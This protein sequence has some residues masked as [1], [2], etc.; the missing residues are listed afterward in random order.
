MTNKLITPQ[1]LYKRLNDGKEIIGIHK[2]R[3]LVK[4]KDF[5]S[6][7]IGNKYYIIENK[8]DEWFEKQAQKFWC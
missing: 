4:R 7:K 8:L 3:S 1:E 5:P 6:F 2:V